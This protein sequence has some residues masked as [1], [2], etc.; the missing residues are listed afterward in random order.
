MKFFFSDFLMVTAKYLSMLEI[1]QD[2]ALEFCRK[3]YKDISIL[4]EIHVNH[5]QKRHIR[6][7]WFGHIFFSPADIH[8]EGLLVLIHSGVEGI[9]EVDT[10]LKGRRV[11]FKATPSNGRVLCA[12]IHFF[13][14][15][16]NYMGN[17][18]EGNYNKTILGD[19][20]CTMD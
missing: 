18:T 4:T 16:H 6:N 9:T 15:L 14:G 17:K 1:W 3:Q 13:D 20:N 5:D 11:S 10:D 7:N 8:T 12:Y 2:L 19:F